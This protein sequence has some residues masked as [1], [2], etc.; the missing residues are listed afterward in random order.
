VRPILM[1]DYAVEGGGMLWATHV[2][3]QLDAQVKRRCDEA[4]KSLEETAARLRARGLTVRTRAVAE[5]QAAV[6]IL[7][8]AQKADADLIALATHGRRGLSRLF[9]GSVA[10]KVVRGGRLPV[11]LRRPKEG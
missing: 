8:E 10:D 7:Q 1:N 5:E 6:G 9:L 4:E 3:E 11:L 2:L